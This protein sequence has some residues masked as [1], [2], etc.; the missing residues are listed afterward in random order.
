MTGGTTGPWLQVQVS[1]GHQRSVD[2]ETVVIRVAES[3][4]EKDAT[5]SRTEDHQWMCGLGCLR[6]AIV[7]KLE[8]EGVMSAS[9]STAPRVCEK[10]RVNF[11]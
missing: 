10:F 8:I 6:T 9:V 4:R 3:Q 5:R 1:S 2:T 11:F 7:S